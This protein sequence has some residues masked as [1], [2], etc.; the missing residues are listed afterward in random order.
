VYHQ[1][2]F[3]VS[4]GYFQRPYIDHSSQADII[5]PTT[6]LED[7]LTKL[8]LSIRSLVTSLVLNTLTPFTTTSMLS[9]LTRK[10]WPIS[11]LA[12]T[13]ASRT[14]QYCTQLGR[15]WQNTCHTIIKHQVH[16]TVTQETINHIEQ[17]VQTPSTFFRQVLPVHPVM[18]YTPPF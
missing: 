12:R 1:Y 2:M 14:L 16:L 9:F 6:L 7:N 13:H 17:K 4:A 11:G 3:E 8:H 15:R 10:R 5:G 18:T